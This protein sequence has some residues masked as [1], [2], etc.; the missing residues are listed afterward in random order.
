MLPQP[1][2]W[3]EFM[4]TFDLNYTDDFIVIYDEFS[5]I[6]AARVW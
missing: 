4:K 3:K 2:Q 1:L 6:G 5:I